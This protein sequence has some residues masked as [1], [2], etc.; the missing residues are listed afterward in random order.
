MFYFACE[1][2]DEFLLLPIILKKQLLVLESLT[3]KNTCNIKSENL[4]CW[5]RKTKRGNTICF[6][7]PL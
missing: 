6:S 3:L 1:F 5:Y 4:H 7:Y 2:R